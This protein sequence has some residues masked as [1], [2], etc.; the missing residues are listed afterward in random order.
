[1]HSSHVP[2][3]LSHSNIALFFVCSFAFIFLYIEAIYLGRSLPEDPHGVSTFW[4]MAS[5]HI[6]RD[7]PNMSF[8][9]SG[10]IPHVP[11]LHALLI[12]SGDFC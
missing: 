5:L 4:T 12:V 2:V 10:F 7:Q 6:D 3:S 9:H 8:A 11:W 1:M